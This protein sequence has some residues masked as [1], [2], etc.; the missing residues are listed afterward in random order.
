MNPSSCNKMKKKTK[1]ASD[2]KVI[3]LSGEITGL[4]AIKLYKTLDSFKKGKHKEIIVDLRKVEY[5]DSNCLGALIYSQTVLNKYDKK[6][7]LSAPHGFI[8]NLFLDCYFDQVFEIRET[9]K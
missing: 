1:T 6:L 9:Y 7:A 4:D 2:K 3:I 8:E 5:M